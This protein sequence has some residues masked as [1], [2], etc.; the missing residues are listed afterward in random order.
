[1]KNMEILFHPN[2]NRRRLF[3]GKTF[4]SLFNKQVRIVYKKIFVVVT[5]ELIVIFLS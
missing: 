1:M 4:V 5:K 3:E 2:G